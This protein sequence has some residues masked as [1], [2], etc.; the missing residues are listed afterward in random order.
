MHRRGEVLRYSNTSEKG[1]SV[2]QLGQNDWERKCSTQIQ[3]TMDIKSTQSLNIVLLPEKRNLSRLDLTTEAIMQY[4]SDQYNVVAQSQPGFPT[5]P[6]YRSFSAVVPPVRFSGPVPAT[7]AGSAPTQVQLPP[8]SPL[9]PSMPPGSRMA[10]RQNKNPFV[11]Y[12]LTNRIKKCAGCPFEF[13]DP[14]G[15]YFLGVVLQHKERDFYT[16]DGRFHMS[17]D[18]NRYYHCKLACIKPRHPYFSSSL[19]RLEPGLTLSDFQSFACAE[20][21]PRNLSE[22][23]LSEKQRETL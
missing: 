19:V 1:I 13:R 23:K 16:K 4:Q 12:S 22:A 20:I 6:P 11:L 5:A 14:N 17:S 21:R 15:P 7:L 3:K 8:Y 10:P 9:Y 18:Q 2:R